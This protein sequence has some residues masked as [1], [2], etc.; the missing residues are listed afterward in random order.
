[1]FSPGPLFFKPRYRYLIFFGLVLLGDKC[2][3]QYARRF[4]VEKSQY[5]LTDELGLAEEMHEVP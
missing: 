3:Y 1:M 4:D 2:R 5:G